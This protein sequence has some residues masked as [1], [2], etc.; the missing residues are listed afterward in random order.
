MKPKVAQKAFILV[1]PILLLAPS[2]R[3]D[4]HVGTG[5]G[6]EEFREAQGNA[7]LEGPVKDRLLGASRGGERPLE[8]DGMAGSAP[9]AKRDIE[10]H[11]GEVVRFDL[12]KTSHNFGGFG[13]QIWAFNNNPQVDLHQRLKELNIKYVRLTRQGA[14]WEQ[15]ASVRD[16]TDRLG[17]QWVYTI[18][19]AP[20]EFTDDKGMLRDV[21]RFT[22]WWAEEVDGLAGRDMRPQYIELMNEPDSEGLWSTGIAPPTYNALVKSVRRALDSRGHQ[23]VRVVGPGLA[24][25]NWQNHNS[26]W[27]RALDPEA[28]AA[29]S[30]WST[31][32]WDDGDLCHGG[33]SCVEKQWPKFGDAAARTDPIKPIFV[34]EYA[35]KESAFHGIEYP[36][37]E[38]GT[39]L[40]YFDGTSGPYYSAT[41][42]VPFAVRLYENTLAL[43]ANGANVSFVWQL[44]DERTDLLTLKKSWGLVDLD[45]KPKPAFEALKTLCPKIPVGARVVA[46]PDQS[47]NHM[48]A[49]A[50]V[51]GDQIVVAISNDSAAEHTSTI[52][53]SNAGSGLQVVEAVAYR[54]ARRGDHE[55]GEPDTGRTTPVEL[56]LTSLAS[57]EHLFDATL[58]FDSTLTVV[59][60]KL[61]MSLAD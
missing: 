15:M 30:V 25:L 36:H 42:T 27:I 44:V 24:H 14:S 2:T 3:S 26:K 55:L 7:V 16:I 4:E 37:P 1:V 41:N 21:K 51:G 19:S 40:T 52:H 6:H 57:G 5:A 47:A 12:S 20:R 17:I 43:L 13:A 18:W 28:T 59:L 54:L 56:T 34:T 23:D 11:S 29:L 9:I 60:Q 53:L 35:T 49:A 50:F 61:N 39:E 31:H 58:P 22:T 8:S 32:S 10:S 33:A 45:G 46:S 48:Y 38:K